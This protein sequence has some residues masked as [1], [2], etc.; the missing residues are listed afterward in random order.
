MSL[1]C[2]ARERLRMSLAPWFTS[3]AIFSISLTSMTRWFFQRERLL[4][5]LRAAGWRLASPGQQRDVEVAGVAGREM[6]QRWWDS[7]SKSHS[8]P[9]RIPESG[10][11]YPVD[12]QQ[13]TSLFLQQLC[14]Q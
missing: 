13:A 11:D 1:R 6:L 12:R 5:C 2:K 9:N 7:R 3:C 14:A 8:F 10:L 4:F